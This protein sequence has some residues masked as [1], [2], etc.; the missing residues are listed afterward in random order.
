MSYSG[1]LHPE[2][3]PLWQAAADPHLRTQ[4]LKGMSG[5]LSVG[6]LVCI[7]FSLSPLSISGG[8]GV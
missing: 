3:L 8:C 5:S 2:S 6:L 1:L 4:A 7:R